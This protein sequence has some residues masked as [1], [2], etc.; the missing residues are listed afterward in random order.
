VAAKLA[1]G[2]TLPDLTNSITKKTSAF[3]EPALDYVVVKIPRWDLGKYARVDEHIGSEMKSVGEVMSIARTFK[4][5]IQKA[6]RMLNLGYEGVVRQKELSLDIQTLRERLKHPDTRRI[7]I[8]SAAL[9]KGLTVAEIYALTGIDPWFLYSIERIV[10]TYKKLIQCK[11]LSRN[12]LSEAK[13]QGFSDK[14]IA[15]VRKTK[16]AIIRKKRK[17]W[18][19][20]PCIKQIDTMAGEFP[21]YTNYLY[22]TYAGITSDI[23]TVGNED[24]IVVLGSGPYSIGTSVEFD[25]CAV[26][27]VKTLKEYG[28]KTIMIN[29]NPETVSTDFDISDYLFFEELTLERLL[30][31][32]DRVKSPFIVS[33]GGQIPNNLAQLLTEHGIKILGSDAR[34]IMNAEDRQTFSAH[35][36]RLGIAQPAWS[37]AYSERQSV[38]N[39]KK[40]GYPVL[41]RP[42]FVLSGKSMLVIDTEE[43]LIQYIRNNRIRNKEY[44]LVMS[45]FLENSTECDLDGVAQNGRIVISV[46]SEHA[47]KGGVHSGDATLIFP[48]IT[49]SKNIINEIHNNTSKIVH[50]LSVNGP[51]NIQFL[52]HR[53]KPYVIECNM[54]ASRS[55]PYI[56]KAVKINFLKIATRISLGE[57]VESD[58]LTIPDYTVVKVPQFSFRRLR[59]ADPVLGVEMGST[60]EVAAFGKDV[61]EAFLT[62][63]LATGVEYPK[64]PSVFL[65][66][67]GD[68]VKKNFLNSAR[69]LITMKYSI[70]ATSG[71][72]AFLKKNNIQTVR[73]GKVYEN[74]HP[75]YMDLLRERK[76]GFAV[77]VPER[78]S[79]A[80][81]FRIEK[82]FSD[83]YIMRRM[84]VDLGIPIFTNQETASLFIES[85]T[86]YSQNDLS[87]LAW[88]E[89]GK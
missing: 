83:G 9:F 48:P 74:V 22:A 25:W 77:V 26:N 45:R 84:S 5:A 81:S 68:S 20:I 82:G 21:T 69:N 6:M 64:Y 43:Q 13:R 54:R 67:G 80:D 1:L 46:L 79:D 60:G 52:I 34:T 70:F 85:I 31:I 57:N 42:S 51:F 16:E 41:I 3:F 36:D 35:L 29:C 65:S 62:A 12:L 56:S 30:D 75:N 88:N 71:T 76:I 17:S 38:E 23:P 37:E 27:T 14:Q 39:A 87:V 44:R 59:G 19:I 49:L 89:Y 73:V 63:L 4:E 55:V 15:C 2:Y 58:N 8:V 66:L 33:V 7:F 18:E 32:Y 53:G 50:A 24:H 11:I 78:A 72:H 40:I 47:E 28:K 61:Y 10:H 86:R